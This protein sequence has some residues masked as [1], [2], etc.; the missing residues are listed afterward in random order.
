VNP[1]D[2]FA[3]LERKIHQAGERLKSAHQK[4]ADQ[5]GDMER[6]RS[7]LRTMEQ[8]IKSLKKER[9]LVKNKV[10]RILNAIDR[11]GGE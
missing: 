3:E 6:L 8:E 7:D 9:E 4:H 1:K 5:L 2:Q 10:E 11:A